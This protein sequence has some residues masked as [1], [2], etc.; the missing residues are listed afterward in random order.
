MNTC[1]ATSCKRID[2]AKAIAFYDKDQGWT[3]EEVKEQV[4][5]PLAKRS[6]HGDRGSRPCVD[7]VLS[8]SGR[9]HEGRQGSEGR[10]KHQSP[11]PGIRGIALSKGETAHVAAED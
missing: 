3:P 5:T 11:G 6:H 8:P 9:D 1:E 10:D 4:L 7:H 2:R